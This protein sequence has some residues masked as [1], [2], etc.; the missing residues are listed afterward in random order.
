MSNEHVAVLAVRCFRETPQPQF[1]CTPNGP[2]VS[3]YEYVLCRSQQSS[4]VGAS[5]VVDRSQSSEAR[6]G[7]RTAGLQAVLDAMLG[8]I[9][10]TPLSMNDVNARWGADLLKFN[11]PDVSVY[12][13]V[14]GALGNC[15]KQAENQHAQQR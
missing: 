2:P 14:M 7:A 6:S 13:F 12:Q 9:E 1:R 15:F 10:S 4:R 11:L 5:G 3:A 8:D